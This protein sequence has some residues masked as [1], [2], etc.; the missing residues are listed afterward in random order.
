[1]VYLFKRVTQL[2][3]KTR[4]LQILERKLGQLFYSK[5][6]LNFIDIESSISLYLL[7]TPN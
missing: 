3:M 4:Y 7:E 2:R 1:M 6:D 5:F